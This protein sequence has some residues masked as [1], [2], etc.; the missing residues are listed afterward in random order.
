LAVELARLGVSHFQLADPESFEFENLNRQEGSG[1]ESVDKN[2]ARVIADEILK[3]NPFANVTVFP[4]GVSESNISQFIDRSDL[5]IDETEMNLPELGVMIAQEARAQNIPVLM[6]LNVGYGCQ[7]TSFNPR[8]YTFEK[9][10]G[11]KKDI[12]VDEARGKEIGLYRWLAHIPSYVDYEVFKDVEL[13][14]ISAP[15]LVQGVDSAAS[16]GA[17]EAIKHLTNKKPVYAPRVIVH[18]AYEHK[19]VVSRFPLARFS[20]SALKMIVRSKLKSK[21]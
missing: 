2:K 10:M 3:I 20:V 5:V 6:A 1:Y 14:K 17:T 11:L 13:G 16:I 8:G 19:T 9:K 12:S 7:V 15:S 18:D 4:N 21:H